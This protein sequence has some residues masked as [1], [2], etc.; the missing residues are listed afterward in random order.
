M[1]SNGP[2]Y[3][4]IILEKKEIKLE[5]SCFLVLK[6]SIIQCYS[7]ENCGICTELGI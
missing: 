5:M 3:P 6:L 2:K 7:N 4:K 1:E